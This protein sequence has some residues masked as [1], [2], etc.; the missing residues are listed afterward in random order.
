MWNEEEGKE[1][2]YPDD[3]PLALRAEHEEKL[4]EIVNQTGDLHPFWFAVPADSLSRLQQVLY[5]T[6]VGLEFHVSIV[7][8]S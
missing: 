4:A 1:N 3:I 8:P 5:L 7:Q 2:A 6:E